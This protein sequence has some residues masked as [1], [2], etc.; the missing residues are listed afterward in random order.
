METFA[1]GSAPGS[2]N[3]V[4]EAAA[5]RTAAAGCTAAAGGGG[6]FVSTFFLGFALPPCPRAPRL[7]VAERTRFSRFP[8]PDEKDAPDCAA[9]GRAPPPAGDCG[10]APRGDGGGA[11]RGS[12]AAEPHA[13]CGLPPFAVGMMAPPLTLQNFCTAVTVNYIFEL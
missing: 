5:G 13:K 6:F 10:G 2:G 4:A 1:D 3:G 9:G 7:R 11:P 8:L 12:A